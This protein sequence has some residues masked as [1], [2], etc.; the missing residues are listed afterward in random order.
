MNGIIRYLVSILGINEEQKLE[1]KANRGDPH[2]AYQLALIL[3]GEK[4][5]KTPFFVLDEKE[6]IFLLLELA[7]DAGVTEA[8]FELGKNSTH[9]FTR[10]LYAARR[11]HLES[12]ALLGEKARAQKNLKESEKKEIFELTDSARHAGNANANRSIQEL[13]FSEFGCKFNESDYLTSL[14]EDKDNNLLTQIRLAWCYLLGIGTPVSLYEAEELFSAI[15]E[16]FRFTLLDKTDTEEPQVLLYPT[17]QQHKDYGHGIS[18]IV[19]NTAK[20][21]HHHLGGVKCFQES[22]RNEAPEALFLVYLAIKSRQIPSRYQD[23]QQLLECS[24]EREFAPAMYHLS[25]SRGIKDKQRLHLINS[26]A[27]KGYYPAQLH[28]AQWLAN[29]AE[30]PGWKVILLTREIKFRQQKDKPAIPDMEDYLIGSVGYQGGASVGIHLECENID[31]IISKNDLKTS[32]EK[33]CTNYLL[34]SLMEDTINFNLALDYVY[35]QIESL[36]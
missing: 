28:I 22:L 6:K 31:T 36:Q 12:A 30:K 35:E 32:V 19:A 18:Y 2:S 10:L 17:D 26:A 16:K 1:D 27:S 9:Q 4:R 7:A 24:A 33:I 5:K 3:L 13:Y 34:L 29:G 15:K 11:G 21:V 25:R 20:Y 8:A 14:I 23:L